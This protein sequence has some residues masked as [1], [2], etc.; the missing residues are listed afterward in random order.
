MFAADDPDCQLRCLGPSGHRHLKMTRCALYS[1]WQKSH[2]VSR[3][4]ASFLCRYSSAWSSTSLGLVHLWVCAAAARPTFSREG[5]GLMCL[6][7]AA[8]PK[9]RPW[10]LGPVST[11]SLCE[12]HAERMDLDRMPAPRRV[13][14]SPLR[15]RA[16]VIAPPD[17]KSGTPLSTDF[18]AV[19]MVL[20]GWCEGS[21]VSR[22]S[23]GADMFLADWRFSASCG[24]SN[25]AGAAIAIMLVFLQSVHPRG[26][27]D[28]RFGLLAP[29][30][31]PR[32]QCW[33]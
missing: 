6:L 30:G 8:L 31:R 14:M 25:K 18:G 23:I 5:T 1:A 26:C 33:L 3:V 15:G 10:H 27:G 21:G 32:W 28:V 2:L 9:E 12:H 24:A 11:S 22:Q 4:A 17:L 19:V 16:R 13:P 20:D 29:A 7:V